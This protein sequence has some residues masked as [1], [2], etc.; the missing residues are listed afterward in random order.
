M[1]VKIISV[2]KEISELVRK[3][4]DARKNKNWKLADEIRDKIQEKGYGIDDT[5]KG[6]EIRKAN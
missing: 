6:P 2:P 5:G 3:R 4:E 1:G